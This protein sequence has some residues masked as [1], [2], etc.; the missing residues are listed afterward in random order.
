MLLLFVTVSTPTCLSTYKLP[1]YS[2]EQWACAQPTHPHKCTLLSPGA[3]LPSL[4]IDRD[5]AGKPMGTEPACPV[6]SWVKNQETMD[7]LIP[8]GEFLKHQ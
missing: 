1:E 4:Q 2:A 6:F 3:Y 5:V 8:D 7:I